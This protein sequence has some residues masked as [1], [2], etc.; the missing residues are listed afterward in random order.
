MKMIMAVVQR[1]E[2]RQLLDALVTAGYAVTYSESRG[3][4]LHQASDTLFIGV[5]DEAVDS[6][7]QIIRENCHACVALRETTAA[8]ASEQLNESTTTSPLAPPRH[9]EITVGGAVVFVWPIE[10]FEKF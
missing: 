5:E 8:E 7:L 10:R 9:S 2:A 6:V 1:A 4:L 3:G